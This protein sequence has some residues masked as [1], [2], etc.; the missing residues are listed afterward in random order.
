MQAFESNSWLH[1]MLW[2]DSGVC[3]PFGKWDSDPLGYTLGLLWLLSPVPRQYASQT[4]SSKFSQNFI[5]LVIYYL[6][7]VDAHL[8]RQKVDGD[9][10]VANIRPFLGDTL[11]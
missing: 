11:G 8:G 4:L 6:Q 5:F 3:I 2:N 1:L 9:Q 7:F 10:L